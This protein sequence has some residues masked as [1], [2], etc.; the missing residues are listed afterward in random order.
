MST[1]IIKVNRG[2]SFEFTVATPELTATD[3][4]YLAIMYPHQRVEDA[5]VIKGIYTVAEQDPESG[6]IKIKLTP[7]DTKYLAT[8]VYYYTVKLQ[9]G[10]SLA[11][12]GATE[13]PNEV[14]TII[15][16]TKFIIN[17]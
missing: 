8:G 2:D 4:V 14:L 12:L 1:K 3:G 15:E 6:E 13:E 11:D 7:Y 10:G 17:D 9:K 5:V 16:R